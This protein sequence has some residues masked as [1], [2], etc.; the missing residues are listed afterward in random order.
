MN[1]P[2]GRPSFIPVWQAFAILL[3]MAAFQAV[4]CQAASSIHATLIPHHPVVDTWVVLHLRGLPVQDRPYHVD[5]QDP[6]GGPASDILTTGRRP[7]LLPIAFIKSVSG[8]YWHLQYR[9]IGA[10]ALHQ[11]AWRTL[12]VAVEHSLPTDSDLYILCASRR[13]QRDLAHRHIDALRIGVRSLRRLPQVAIAA[14][15]GGIIGPRTRR[16]THSSDLL[17]MIAAG[18]PI[19]QLGALRPPPVNGLAWRRAQLPHH[20]NSWMLASPA[21]PPP[22]P[23]TAALRRIR[24][25]QLAPPASWRNIVIICGLLGLF[26]PCLAFAAASAKRIGWRVVWMLTA[27]AATAAVALVWINREPQVNSINWQWQMATQNHAMGYSV[28]WRVV[29]TLVPTHIEISGPSALPVAWSPR[30]WRRLQA[31]IYF[32]DSP[33][34]PNKITFRLPKGAA[35]IVQMQ[36]PYVGRPTKAASLHWL[37]FVNGSLRQP[38]AGTSIGLDDWM[39]HQP[40]AIRPSIRAWLLLGREGYTGWRVAVEKR[41]IVKPLIT[42]GRR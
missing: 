21:P 20:I 24:L 3:L 22:R 14:F 35:A 13:T 31:T 30:S 2:I 8:R 42:G 15:S 11:H 1:I 18:I 17:R 40:S 27:S 37:D 12:H 38:P 34:I 23:L 5:I 32:S 29:R 25:P 6:A 10:A 7:V 28:N 16:L 4:R 26:V 33:T 41:L 19:Y 9:I 39:L 36:T